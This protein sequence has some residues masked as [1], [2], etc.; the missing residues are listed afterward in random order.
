MSSARPTASAVARS[1]RAS[2]RP[3]ALGLGAEQVGLGALA[4]R[5]ALACRR[6]RGVVEHLL[7]A[8]QVHELAGVDE[9]VVGTPHRRDQREADPGELLLGEGGVQAQDLSP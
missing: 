6:D 4:G 2:P 9:L 8:Q 7:L 3:Q 1:A 5:V